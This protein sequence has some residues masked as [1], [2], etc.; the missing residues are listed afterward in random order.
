MEGTCIHN[1]SENAI[2]QVQVSNS[3]LHACGD[4][5]SDGTDYASNVALLDGMMYVDPLFVDPANGDFHLS[6]ASPL[7]DAGPSGVDH[8]GDF[9]EEPEP[10]GCA[11]N[12]GA[13]GGTDEAATKAGA[14]HCVCDVEEGG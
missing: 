14:D 8:C 4:A 13:Y 12:Y 11:A 2:A 5:D 6:S 7:I 9:S 10:N 3:N 1:D